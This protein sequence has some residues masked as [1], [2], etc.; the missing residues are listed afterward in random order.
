MVRINS[1]HRASICPYG[2]DSEI[3]RRS[4]RMTPNSLM[5]T[6]V[7][8]LSEMSSM[9][10]NVGSKNR[11]K[12]INALFMESES[13]VEYKKLQPERFRELFHFGEVQDEFPTFVRDLIV[14]LPFVFHR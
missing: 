9:S 13:T 8:L 10:S 14:P 6:P 7:V 11:N 12:I 5:M 3:P 4:I 2:S 1:R